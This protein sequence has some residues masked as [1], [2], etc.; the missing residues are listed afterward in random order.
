L[1]SNN[2]PLLPWARNARKWPAVPPPKRFHGYA[3]NWALS[4]GGSRLIAVAQSTNCANP[5]KTLA[6]V[7]TLKRDEIRRGHHY[8]RLGKNG[9][10]GRLTGSTIKK[11]FSF[12]L[13]NRGLL[14]EKVALVD[15][16]NRTLQESAERHGKRLKSSSAIT[17]RVVDVGGQPVYRA[18]SADRAPIELPMA[19][20]GCLSRIKRCR[21]A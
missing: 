4:A 17:V 7:L 11:A 15:T 14:P 10:N 6:A 19:S 8:C 13:G 2:W 5:E 12:G 16:F 21:S 18:A 3:V 9:S 1:I 20:T